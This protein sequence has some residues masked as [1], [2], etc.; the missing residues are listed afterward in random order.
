MSFPNDDPLRGHQLRGHFYFARE[1][2][3]SFRVNIPDYNN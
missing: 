1:G 3:L 2:T